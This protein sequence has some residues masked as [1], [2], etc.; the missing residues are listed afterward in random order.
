MSDRSEWG[1]HEPPSKPTCRYCR[2][3]GRDPKNPQYRCEDCD[4]DNREETE[5]EEIDDE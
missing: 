1:E 3:T 4:E 2:G 5:E